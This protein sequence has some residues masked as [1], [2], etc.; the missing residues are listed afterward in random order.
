MVAGGG[1][2]VAG[3]GEVVAGGGEVVAEERVEVK[4]ELDRL[5]ELVLIRE[6]GGGGLAT[7]AGGENGDQTRRRRLRA[8]ANPAGSR[9]SRWRLFRGSR[10]A[11]GQHLVNHVRREIA[12]LLVGPP[13]VVADEPAR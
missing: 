1:E 8:V 9:R 13:A 12:E 5:G 2:V 11:L 4:D 6:V 7:G 10:E 3:G